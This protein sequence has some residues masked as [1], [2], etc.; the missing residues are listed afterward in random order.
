MFGRLVAPISALSGSF[1]GGDARY[2]VGAPDFASLGVLGVDLS[3][4]ERVALAAAAPNEGE[5][6][7]TS[8]GI[9]SSL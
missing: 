9:D 3:F 6:T 7:D 1:R 5:R 4:P 8:L 2:L